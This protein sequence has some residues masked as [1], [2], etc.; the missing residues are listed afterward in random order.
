MT[1]ADIEFIAREVWL[2]SL[3]AQ[4]KCVSWLFTLID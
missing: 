3:D 2:A 1:I 4:D